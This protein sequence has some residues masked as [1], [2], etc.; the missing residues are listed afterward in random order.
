MRISSNLGLG[1]EGGG[2]MCCSGFVSAKVGEK[3]TEVGG[4]TD[5]AAAPG[6]LGDNGDS[7]AC[8]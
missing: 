2:V 3:V 4:G 1:A 6:H 7:A 8:S 5:R